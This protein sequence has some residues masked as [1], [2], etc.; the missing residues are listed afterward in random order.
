M[1]A[2]APRSR[3]SLYLDLI[4]WNRPA[5]WLVL[6]WPT[7]AA[8]WVAADGFPGWHLLAV[9][10]AGTVLMRSAGCTINDIADRDFD[11]HVKRTT[12]RPITSGQLSV[13][14]AALVGVVLTLV[15]F[16]LVLT[17]RWEAVAWSVPAVLFTILYPFTKR[18]FAMPQAFL[19]IA[20]NFGIVIAFAAVQGRVPATAWV[21]WL[22]N[23]FLVLAYDTEYAMVDRDDDLKIGMKTSA[24]TLGR[25][26]VAAIMG[27]FVLCLGLTAWVLAP[28]G[29]GW[30]LWLGLGVAA[31][32]V[33]WHFTL[34][35]D[36]T[37]EG[38]FTAFS[39]SHWIG[40]AIFAG[41]ALGYLLR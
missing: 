17:T 12:Q 21:L 35:K 15:A 33:A 8:L 20:F 29:L 2:V 10:V 18:F 31:A 36:R 16:V 32:Q 39:K 14:E 6:V 24:I 7:L 4:R 38:C 40:A 22:A 34:I 11:R 41:V 37:R 9:F 25:F 3:L 13:R 27:F 28:Y 19:G 1:S 5:G 30:P 23:L 26:D